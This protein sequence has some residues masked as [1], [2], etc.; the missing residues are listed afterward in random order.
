MNHLIFAILKQISLI[1]IYRHTG[2]YLK[3]VTL[4]L[5]LTVK[6]NYGTIRFIST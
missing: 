1:K 2:N 4:N 5:D 3:P 6:L